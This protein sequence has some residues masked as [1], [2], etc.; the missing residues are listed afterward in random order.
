MNSISIEDILL[1][2]NHSSQTSISININNNIINVEKEL[3][4]IQKQA[5]M[6]L[7]VEFSLLYPVQH[8]IDRPGT[9]FAFKCPEGGLNFRAVSLLYCTRTLS[10]HP[11]PKYINNNYQQGQPSR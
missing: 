3:L 4:I 8:K 10:N 6:D 11:I 2:A 7:L 5:G 9:Y 1:L